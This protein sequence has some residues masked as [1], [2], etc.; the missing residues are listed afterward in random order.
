MHI[1]DRMRLFLLTF[2]SVDIICLVYFNFCV[3]VRIFKTR[4]AEFWMN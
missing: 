4:D 2:E 3:N 1:F